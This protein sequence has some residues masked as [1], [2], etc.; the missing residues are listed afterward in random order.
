MAGNSKI[1]RRIVHRALDLFGAAS[2]MDH[3]QVRLLPN[4]SRPPATPEE[5]L[6][7]RELDGAEPRAFDAVVTR[8]SR[9]L[10]QEQLKEGGWATDIGVMGPGLSAG[11]IAAVLEAGNGHLWTITPQAPERTRRPAV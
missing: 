5:C 9:A 2:P 3:R 4:T 6:I 1:V 10:Y 11:E 8:V 7:V